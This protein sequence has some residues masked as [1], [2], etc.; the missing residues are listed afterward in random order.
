[1]TFYEIGDKGNPA[2]LLIHGMGCNSERSFSKPAKALSKKYRMIM[3]NLDGYDGKGTTF[4]TISDQAKKIAAFLHEQYEGKLYACV[5]MSMGGFI[6]MDL[7]CRYEMNIEHLVLDSGYVPTMPFAAI[8]SK[9]TADGFMQLLRR[10][11]SLFTVHAMEYLM[12]YVFRKEQLY[13][14]AS[15]RTIYNSEYSCMTWQIPDNLEILNRPSTIFLHGGKE[16]F[17]KRG[18]RVLKKRLPEMRVFYTGDYGHGELM[19]TDPGKYTKV[20]AR[21]IALAV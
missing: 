17:I 2:V 5:G 12:A 10:Y 13:P 7:V 16:K 11:P 18:A 4:T 8:F 15:W 6:A 1:M 14:D 21:A 9:L 20:I 3:V 19:F